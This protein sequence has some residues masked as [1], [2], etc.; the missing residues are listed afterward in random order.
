[1]KEWEGKQEEKIANKGK[2][3]KQRERRRIINKGGG[4]NNYETQR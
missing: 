2:D 4:I 3:G 1:M